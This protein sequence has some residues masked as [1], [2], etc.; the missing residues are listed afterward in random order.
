MSI[1]I[2]LWKNRSFRASKSVYNMMMRS[3]IYHHESDFERILFMASG[4]ILSCVGLTG[5]G[6]GGC[7]HT[8]ELSTCNDNSQG[9]LFSPVLSWSHA[10]FFAN[11]G[12]VKLAPAD[13]IFFSRHVQSN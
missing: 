12:D 1:I 2:G 6:S 7:H 10:M 5:C 11:S 9:Q 3:S 13:F 4:E 8:M